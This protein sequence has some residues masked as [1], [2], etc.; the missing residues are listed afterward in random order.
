M[1]PFIMRGPEIGKK[2]LERCNVQNFDNQVNAVVGAHE[3]EYRKKWQTQLSLTIPTRM[4]SM[5]T[6]FQLHNMNF[7]EP[8]DKLEIYQCQLSIVT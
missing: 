6:H 2:T 5:I 1:K 8:Q 7:I 4:D 3:K